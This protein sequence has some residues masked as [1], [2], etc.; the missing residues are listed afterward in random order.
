[1]S[2]S[3]FDFGLAFF[4]N[5][6]NFIKNGSGPYFYLP[7]LQSHL[8]ARWWNEVFKVAQDELGISR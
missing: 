4:H 1:M 5:A 2:A 8:E 6:E 7:K 3:L